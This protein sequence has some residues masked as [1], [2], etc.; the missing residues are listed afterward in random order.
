MAKWYSKYLSVY[1]KKLSE[2]PSDVFATIKGNISKI[3]S[4]EPLVTVS[5]IAYNEETH[6][7]SCIWS[8]SE[9]KCSHPYEIIGVNNDSKDNTAAVF[10]ECG[11]TCYTEMNHSCGWARSRG[12]ANAKG[13]FHLNIDGDTIY[14]A[15]Y[16]Q[17]M[18]DTLLKDNTVGVCSSWSY[19][20]D[21]K[22][23]AIGLFFYELVRDFYLWLVHFQ[24][25]ELAVRGVV[26]GYR[27]DLAQQIGIRT[28]IIRGEDGSLALELK[29]HGRIRFIHKRKARAITGYGTMDSGGS[30]FGRF[31]EVFKMRIKSLPSMF[32]KKKKYEDSDDNLV[33]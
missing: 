8:L 29:K 16:V 17:T 20:P 31:V 9:Q 24:R 15:D 27:T 10:A 1:G 25:P 21:E 26:F 30:F 3:D 5:V 23:S 6:L 18:V 32:V 7:A 13:R 22:H 12:L 14:P 33:K 2:V 11:V 28:D 19:F 4:K